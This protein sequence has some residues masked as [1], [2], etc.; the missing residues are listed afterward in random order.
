MKKILSFATLFVMLF[1]LLSCKEDADIIFDDTEASESDEISSIE[2]T[3]TEEESIK[4]ASEESSDEDRSGNESS[5]NEETDTST[6][7]ANEQISSDSSEEET[8]SDIIIDTPPEIIT[9][10]GSFSTVTKTVESYDRLRQM[11]LS[12]SAYNNG[13]AYTESELNSTKA[14]AETIVLGGSLTYKNAAKLMKHYLDGSGENFSIDMTSFLSDSIAVQNRNTDIEKALRAAEILA[15]EGE[16]VDIYQ[17]QE[18]IFHNLS[19]DWRYAVGSY[20][21]SIEMI[22]ITFDG[23][24]Y[25]ATLNYK[26]IDFYNW[27][28]S[29]S[30]PVFTGTLGTI[31]GSVSPKDLH[32]LHKAGMAQEF[33]SVG[34]I[35]YTFSW[36]AGDSAQSVIQ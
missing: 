8:S 7:E 24:T 21:T 25:T 22:G 4:E 36:K 29:D 13:T 10:S 12:K 26:V 17:M 19:G 23:K 5:S 15:I 14:I 16:S 35:S 33:L 3:A 27:D 18:S 9:E 11:S 2:E 30:S 31:I 28:E 6:E 32:Q 34:E 1:L 20:F